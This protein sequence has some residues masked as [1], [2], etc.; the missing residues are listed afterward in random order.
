MKLSKHY[1]FLIQ[2]LQK[3]LAQYIIPFLLVFNY[4]AIKTIFY[5]ILQK[6]KRLPLR[7][8]FSFV[9][10]KSACLHWGCLHLS[11]R[12]FYRPYQLLQHAVI[13]SIYQFLHTT[14]ADFSN[15]MN[16]FVLFKLLWKKLNFA[17]C[18]DFC[19]LMFE[20]G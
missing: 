4:H 18:F 13:Q 6:R 10:E 17:L 5:K 9:Q 11:A 15:V 3:G 7:T 1:E 16:Y 14:L 8:S 19:N 20:T 2:Y 12:S